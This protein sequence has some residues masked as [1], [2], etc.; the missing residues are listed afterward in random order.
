MRDIE[1]V[2]DVFNL[3]V[4]SNVDRMAKD[5]YGRMPLHYAYKS[6]NMYI[7]SKLMEDM[8]VEQ[9]VEI[10]NTQDLEMISVFGMLFENMSKNEVSSSPLT[11]EV[12]NIVGLDILKLNPFVRFHKK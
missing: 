6:G 10:L 4:Q 11:Q 5:K 9:K 8:S 12:L 3:L 1:L 2:N 7:A